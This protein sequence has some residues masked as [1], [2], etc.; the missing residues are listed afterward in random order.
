[1]GSALTAEPGGFRRMREIVFGVSAEERVLDTKNFPAFEK[2]I[3]SIGEVCHAE[4]FKDERLWR[5]HPERW[6]ESLV[7]KN[8]SAD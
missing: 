3:A 2:L 5:R 6:L 4:G 1:M 7:I 8:L